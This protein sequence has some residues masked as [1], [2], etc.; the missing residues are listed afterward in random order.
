MARPGR[1]A[2]DEGAEAVNAVD[3]ALGDEKIEGAIDRDR[4]RPAPFCGKRLDDVVRPDGGMSSRHRHKHAAALRRQ[5]KP[6]L[7]TDA[8][9]RLQAAGK[10]GTVIVNVFAGHARRKGS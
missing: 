7:V 8:L 5:P 6:A 3:Q 9:G 2:E 10:T 4:R 1:D